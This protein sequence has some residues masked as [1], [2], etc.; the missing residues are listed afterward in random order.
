MSEIAYNKEIHHYVKNVISNATKSYFHLLKNNRDKL[1]ER[2]KGIAQINE[3]GEVIIEA[4]EENQDKLLNLNYLNEILKEVR[5]RRGGL[6]SFFNDPDRLER[7]FDYHI[8][9]LQHNSNIFK[10]IANRESPLII[11]TGNLKSKE[12]IQVKASD[13]ESRR[14]IS[15]PQTNPKIIFVPLPSQTNQTKKEGVSLLL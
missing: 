7:C 12:P 13:L 9:N 5:D 10:P 3:K 15:V 1:N 4:L 2:L 14:F 8:N 6:N 11:V